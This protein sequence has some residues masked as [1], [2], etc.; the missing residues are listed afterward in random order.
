MKVWEL[1]DMRAEPSSPAVLASHPE[2]RAVALEL[3]A[4]DELGDHEVHERAWLVVARGRGEP[5]AGDGRRPV[6]A[7][8]IAVFDPGERHAVRAVEDSRLLLLL[9]PWPAE[10]R[11]E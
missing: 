8:S 3:P 1:S 10:E 2:G 11:V 9:T 5:G 4:G 7:G 6:G